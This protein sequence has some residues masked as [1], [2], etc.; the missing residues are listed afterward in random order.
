MWILL[1]T[2]HSGNSSQNNQVAIQ[3]NGAESKNKMEDG[4]VQYENRKSLLLVKTVSK[5][6]LCFNE[7]LYSVYKFTAM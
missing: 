5:C 3:R 6:G 1:P 7:V 2:R 4:E